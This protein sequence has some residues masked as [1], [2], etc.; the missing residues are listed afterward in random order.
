[1]EKDTEYVQAIYCLANAIRRISNNPVLR[2]QICNDVLKLRFC[3]Q[4]QRNRRVIGERLG[5]PRALEYDQAAGQ[6]HKIAHHGHKTSDQ[7]WVLY[8]I[9]SDLLFNLLGDSP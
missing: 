9:A 6:R 8:R 2:D 7:S 1:M 5:E 3:G 4:T